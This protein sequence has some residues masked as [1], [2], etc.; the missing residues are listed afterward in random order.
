MQ[1]PDNFKP[2]TRYCMSGSVSH[3]QYTTYEFY[4]TKA[5]DES[6]RS[7]NWCC[8]M[9]F[10]SGLW[11]F[12]SCGS[13]L[14]IVQ[15]IYWHKYMMYKGQFYPIEQLSVLYF[16][17][18][19]RFKLQDKYNIQKRLYI[20]KIIQKLF[21][22]LTINFSLIYWKS[23]NMFSCSGY[24]EHLSQPT[25]TPVLALHFCYPYFHLT[26][27]NVCHALMDRLVYCNVLQILLNNLQ[28]SMLYIGVIVGVPSV[29]HTTVEF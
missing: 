10:R 21:F 4:V 19:C 27:T 18:S 7:H 25:D 29:H 9:C 8:R 5:R 3:V 28:V 12:M 23:I 2:A 14:G 15:L 13:C 20:S 16:Y 17:M 1:Q 26:L 11:F 6:L 24:L 22:S